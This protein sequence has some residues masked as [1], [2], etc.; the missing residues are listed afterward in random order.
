MQASFCGAI[1]DVKSCETIQ[2]SGPLEVHRVVE[3]KQDQSIGSVLY[4][5]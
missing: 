3:P 4:K 5:Q 2:I 1:T